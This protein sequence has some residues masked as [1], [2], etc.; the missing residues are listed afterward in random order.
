MMILLV[1]LPVSSCVYVYI[2]ALTIDDRCYCPLRWFGQVRLLVVLRAIVN[3]I[4]VMIVI[5][6]PVIVLLVVATTIVTYRR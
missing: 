3:V 1:C 6:L 2:Y 4:L 5:V